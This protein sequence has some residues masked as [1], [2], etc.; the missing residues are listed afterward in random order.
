MD[1]EP[2]Y[3]NLDTNARIELL[4]AIGRASEALAQFEALAGR[5]REASLVATKLD[6]A[7]LWAGRLPVG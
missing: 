4:A 5:S 1:K 7:A 3:T 6:E 2:D